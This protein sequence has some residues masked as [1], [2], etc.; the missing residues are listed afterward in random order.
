KRGGSTGPPDRNRH[1]TCGNDDIGD[2]APDQDGTRCRKTG[3]GRRALHDL[4]IVTQHPGRM[5]SLSR[6]VAAAIVSLTLAS[7]STSGP[8][9]R[10]GAPVSGQ[11]STTAP[12]YPAAAQRTA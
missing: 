1:V 3:G 4:F 8:I 6:L 7:C 11:A 5:R 2:R 12:R 9:G 10:I